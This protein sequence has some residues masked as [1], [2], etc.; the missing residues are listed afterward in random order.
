MSPTWTGIATALAAWTV[1]A[2]PCAVGEQVALRTD[3]GMF[4]RAADDGT[5]RADRLVPGEQETFE[6]GG[7]RD[8]PITLK[9]YRGR[10]L[11]AE[12]RDAKQLR[13]DSPRAEPAERE[14]FVLVPAVARA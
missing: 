4:L 5:L 3:S 14:T 9:T 2:L 8:G 6:L 11:L 13:A 1:A 7:D 12:G 10:F